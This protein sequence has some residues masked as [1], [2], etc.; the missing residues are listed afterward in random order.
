MLKRL[1]NLG[2]YA[3]VNF[4]QGGKYQNYISFLILAL[5]FFEAY[6]ETKFGIWFYTNKYYTL[7]SFVILFILARIL[8]GWVHRKVIWK[9]EARDI[10]KQNPLFMD[11]YRKVNEIHKKLNG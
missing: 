10:Q 3:K 11:M 8:V 4:D 1:I 2:I 7:P 6:E 5:V 9:K